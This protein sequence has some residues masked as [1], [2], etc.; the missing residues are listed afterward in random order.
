[1]LG[2]LAQ[3]TEEMW[4]DDFV[5][6]AMRANASGIMAMFE[7]PEYKK[8]NELCETELVASIGGA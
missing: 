8:F 1:M 2:G 5:K 7:A 6:T 4:T 3:V